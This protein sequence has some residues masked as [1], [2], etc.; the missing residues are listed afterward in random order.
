M[1]G[2]EILTYR[3]DKSVNIKEIV[4]SQSIYSHMILFVCFNKRPLQV[5]LRPMTSNKT[6]NKKHSYLKIRDLNLYI[7]NSIGLG[8]KRGLISFTDTIQ[9]LSKCCKNVSEFFLFS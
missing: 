1:Q 6:I 3:T 7:N 2:K 9:L 5:L 4:I 8:T